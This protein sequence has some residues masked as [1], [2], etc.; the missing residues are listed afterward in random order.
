MEWESDSPCHSHTYPWQGRRSPG[1]CISLELD[2]RDCGAVP[3]LGLLLTVERRIGS[4]G[5]EGGDCGGK[6]LWRKARQPWKQGDTAESHVGGGVITI[7]SSLT[8]HAS[9]CSWVTEGL[10][11]QTPDTLNYRAGPTQ[12]ALRSDWCTELQSRTVAKEWKELRI[13]SETSGTIANAPT[14]ES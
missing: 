7:L 4:R 12:G 5:C 3:G 2:F 8:W 11:Y 13:V 9:I 10:A 6:C 1:R 14:F